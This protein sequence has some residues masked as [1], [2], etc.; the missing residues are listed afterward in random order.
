[1]TS[2]R[3]LERSRLLTFLHSIRTKT[4]LFPLACVLRAASWLFCVGSW[5]RKQYLKGIAR[6]SMKSAIPVISVGSVSVGGAGKTPVIQYLMK[7]CSHMRVGYVSRGYGRPIRDAIVCYGDALRQS[8]SVGDEAFLLAKRDPSLLVGIGCSKRKMAKQLIQKPLDILFLDDGLQRYDIPSHLEV[9][10]LPE[11]LLF[12]RDY[13]FPFGLLR[14]PLRRLKKSDLLFVIKENPFTPLSL[15]VEELKQ[16]SFT[17]YVV[18]E[19]QCS[20]WID[21]HGCATTPPVKRLA[22]FSAIAR[23]ERVVVLLKSMGYE[24][25]DTFFLGD[26]EALLSKNFSTWAHYWHR[27]GVAVVGTEKDWARHVRWPQDLQFCSFMQVDLAILLGEERIPNLH[28][29]VQRVG[30]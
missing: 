5:A 25:V 8:S 13:L 24:M 14:E 7:K 21:V 23:P 29:S 20:G 6:C 30:K 1:M 9:G 17:R 26:H 27:K 10:V 18:A 16:Q 11:K 19:Q 15:I 4:Y 12:E 2:S 28:K 3:S 22:L